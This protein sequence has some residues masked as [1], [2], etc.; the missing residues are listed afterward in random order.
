MKQLKEELQCACAERDNILSEKRLNNLEEL[1]RLQANITSLAEERDQL[2]EI[3]QGLRE[4]KTQLK[5]P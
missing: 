5:M 3:S 4:E 2:Q 1:E